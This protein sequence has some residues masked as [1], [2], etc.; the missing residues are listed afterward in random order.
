MTCKAA[1][2]FTPDLLKYHFSDDHPFNPVRLKLTIDLLEAYGLL[3]EN[4]IVQP[5]SA[6][7]EELLTFHEERYLQMLKKLSEPGAD[8]AGAHLYG[9]GT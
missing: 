2:V 8:D 6:G 1:F 7:M 9:L 5:R 3:E 4:E